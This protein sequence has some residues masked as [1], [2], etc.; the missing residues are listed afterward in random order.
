MNQRLLVS[1]ETTQKEKYICNCVYT[2]NEPVVLT[3][4][5]MLSVVVH[6][7]YA[8]QFNPL[9]STCNFEE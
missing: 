3:T 1:C 4:L 5:L 2:L 7:Y 9:Y 8:V 6:I